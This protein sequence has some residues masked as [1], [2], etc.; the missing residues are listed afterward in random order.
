MSMSTDI[1]A[2]IRAMIGRRHK[3]TRSE[4]RGL[5]CALAQEGK[6]DI[7]NQWF[8]PRNRAGRPMHHDG[9][10]E[11]GYAQRIAYADGIEAA[12]CDITVISI[13]ADDDPAAASLASSNPGEVRYDEPGSMHPLLR[14]TV[15]FAAEEGTHDYDY[16]RR[17]TRRLLIV[18]D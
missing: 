12:C 11:S 13:L 4:M 7:I 1:L 16:L 9:P 15:M 18:T 5:L 3:I 17:R 2:T 10:W 8:K 14:A 6:V